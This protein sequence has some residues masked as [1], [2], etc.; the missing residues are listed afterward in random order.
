MRKFILNSSIIGALFGAY[1]AIQTTRR[2]PRDWRLI[3]MW[4]G[5][6]ITVA[7]AV[8]TVIQEDRDARALNAKLSGGTR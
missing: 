8:G 7:L 3:L 4:L 6:G 1:S 5:W 2:G